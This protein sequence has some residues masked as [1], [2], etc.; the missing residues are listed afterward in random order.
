MAF[1]CPTSPK[2]SSFEKNVSL[3]YATCY[4]LLALVT[5]PI[6]VFQKLM[7]ERWRA[8]LKKIL[9]P[10]SSNEYDL[11]LAKLGGPG[12]TGCFDS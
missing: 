2:H 10:E 7:Q 1:P 8:G 9:G 3:L 6:F 12:R 4:A 5:Y 11:L